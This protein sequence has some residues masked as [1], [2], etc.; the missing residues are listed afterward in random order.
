L[1]R[2]KNSNA[3]LI[4]RPE[5]FTNMARFIN[6]VNDI[7]K[8]NVETIRIVYKERPVVLLIAKR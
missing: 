3:T 8:A 7:K 4:I 2:G 5:K 6:G 1:Q